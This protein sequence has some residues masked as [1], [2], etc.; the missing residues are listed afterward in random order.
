MIKKITAILL[1]FFFTA[2]FGFTGL[3]GFGAHTPPPSGVTLNCGTD[4]INEDFTVDPE[5]TSSGNSNVTGGELVSITAA[6]SNDYQEEGFGDQT[7]TWLCHT[8]SLDVGF[9]IVTNNHQFKISTLQ[10]GGSELFGL[11]IRNVSGTLKFRTEHRGDG[12]NITSILSSPLPTLG[13]TYKLTYHYKQ[14]TEVDAAD[15]IVEM[16]IDNDQVVN[17]INL[18][19]DTRLI[20]KTRMGA[21]STGTTVDGTTRIDDVEAGTTGAGPS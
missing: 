21:V 16:W 11:A 7:N 17:V 19:N 8:F 13:Q 9:V 4:L 3:I 15:G 12:G 14:N 10:D 5:W 6:G 1:A 18:D 20:D 2:A